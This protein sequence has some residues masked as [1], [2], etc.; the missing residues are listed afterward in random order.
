MTPTAVRGR[1]HTYR[2]PAFRVTR[3]TSGLPT[4][5]VLGAQGVV[6]E[7]VRLLLD[8]RAE[9]IA[10]V[11]SGKDA[12][13]LAELVAPDVVVVDELL[14]DGVAEGFVHSLFRTGARV[15]VLCGPSET[16]RL[17]DLVA[18]GATGLVDEEGTPSDV[19][20]AVLVLAAG[21]AVL[22]PDVIAAVATDWRRTHRQGAGN[23]RTAELTDRERD[24]LGAVADGL[25]T[26]AV[27][28]H[29][30]ISVKTVES[31]K[32]RIF[33][34]LGVRSQ[35]EAVAVAL[36]TASPVPEANGGT[37]SPVP[38]ANGGTASPV[39]EANGGTASPPGPRPGPVR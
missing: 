21:G 20:A 18:Q 31:H 28:H 23:I 14:D 36:G 30:G 7:A 19:A 24:V 8:G 29:L 35:A 15:L 12:V 27:A 34:K 13:A 2:R 22:P 1:R 39:P 3:Y 33:G 6:V 9:V 37:A 32:T 26:K 10:E 16:P 5:I 25:S 11:R 38:E 4:V 17:V